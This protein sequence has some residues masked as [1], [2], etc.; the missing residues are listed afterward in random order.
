M[1]TW[2]DQTSNGKD[3]IRN[4]AS[5]RTKSLPVDCI[6]VRASDGGVTICEPTALPALSVAQVE[7]INY[8]LAERGMSKPNV[9]AGQPERE[10]KKPHG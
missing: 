4:D 7:M 10:A 5:G 2:I 9:F 8:F 1:T 3:C 6:L